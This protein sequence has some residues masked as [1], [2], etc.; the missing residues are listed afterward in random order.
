MRVTSLDPVHSYMNPVHI[1]LKML[2]VTYAD[3]IVD[4]FWSN[5]RIY[6]TLIELVIKSKVRLSQ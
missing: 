1:S 2:I 5:N 3:A 6:S 4:G